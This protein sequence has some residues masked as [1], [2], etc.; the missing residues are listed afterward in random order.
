MSYVERMISSGQSYGLLV[1]RPHP[2][3]YGLSHL[4]KG[5]TIAK[6][7]LMAIT[8]QTTCKSSS[9]ISYS[10]DVSAIACIGSK[11]VIFF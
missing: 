8:P 2:K 9:V 1:S 6:Q 10:A 7:S 11:S 4:Q 5:S 3:D